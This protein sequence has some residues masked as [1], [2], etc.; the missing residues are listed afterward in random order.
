MIS[1]GNQG[2]YDASIIEFDIEIVESIG[3]LQRQE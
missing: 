2:F 1:V 3:W